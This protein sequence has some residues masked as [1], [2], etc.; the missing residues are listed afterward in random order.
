MKCG[1]MNKKFHSFRTTFIT[2]CNHNHLPDKQ[3]K[4]VVGHSMGKDTASRFYT[5][6][7]P[8]KQLYDEVV[9]KVD[10]DIDLSPYDPDKHEAKEESKAA[11]AAAAP[12]ASSS[13]GT[14]LKA[15]MPGVVLKTVAKEGSKVSSGDPVIVLEAMKMENAVGAPVSGTLVEFLV[16]KGDHVDGGQALARFE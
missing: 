1:V 6:E 5:A 13:G 2:Y 8:V 3:W 10:F 12:A 4:R 11:P 15:P 16:K 14:T 7:F 9:S